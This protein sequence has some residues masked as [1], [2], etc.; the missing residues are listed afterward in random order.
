MNFI[1]MPHA[2][3]V[4]CISANYICFY[5]LF[6][7][8]SGCPKKKELFGLYLVFLLCYYYPFHIIIF[9]FLL[10]DQ[11]D[12]CFIFSLINESF[13][14]SGN[15]IYYCLSFFFVF[16]FPLTTRFLHCIKKR[17]K[18]DFHIFLHSCCFVQNSN[19]FFKTQIDI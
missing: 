17:K 16:F 19:Y 12:E 9:S 18:N 13:L 10:F 15:N 5:E 7:S 14:K 8:I 4:L 3:W 11:F 1:Q 6:G 2:Y